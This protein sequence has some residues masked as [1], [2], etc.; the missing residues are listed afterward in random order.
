MRPSNLPAEQG[1]FV[2][3]GDELSE[4]ERL[5]AHSRLVTVTGAGGVG[6]TRLALR[7]AAER[8]KR[9]C[10]GVRV[11]YLST[12]SDPGLLDHALV[13]ALGVNDR[14]GRPPR[15]VLLDHLADRQLLLVLDG[16]EHLAGECARLVRE[17]LRRAPGLHVLTTGR[18]PLRTTGEAVL[19]LTPL[20]EDD[21]VRL[22]AD[23]AASA[24]PGFRVD[25][26]NRGEVRELCRRLDGIPLALE[27]AAGR[28][29][30]LSVGGMLHRLEGRRPGLPSDGAGR[31][32]AGHPTLRAAVGWSHE[33]CTPEERLLWARLSV[34]AGHVDPEAVEYVCTGPE[35]PPE[36]IPQVLDGLMTQSVVCREETAAGVRY[37]MPE[38]VR[39]YGAERLEALGDT[40]RLRRRHRD[41]H[42]G[43]AT[44]WELDW[45]GPRQAEVAACADTALPDLRAALELCMETPQETY[46]AQ[47]LAGTL[48]FYW[49]GCGRL[50]EGRHWLDRAVAL[51][52]A[53]S[54]NPRHDATRL[55]ALWVLGHVAILQGDGA[56]AVRALEECDAAARAAG[57][58]AA[59]AC[60]AH[61]RGSLA[62]LQN[63]LPGAERLLRR[64]LAEYRELGELNCHVLMA[65][66]TLAMSLLLQGDPEE[67]AAL[68]EEVRSVCAEHGDHWTRAYALYVLAYTCWIRGD[69][70]AARELL[71]GC[72]AVSHGFGDLVGLVPAI[73]LLAL[74]TACSGDAV[75]AA[76]LLGAAAP[77]REAVGLRL[78]DSGCFRAPVA[79]CE[80]R[81]SGVL[82]TTE[83][84]ARLAE[85]RELTLDAAVEM[86]L[87]MC[88]VPARA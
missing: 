60:A 7:A 41:W 21:A 37:R 56:Q 25:D 12:L 19:P 15:T 35:L 24:A 34:F 17:M 85:G 70:G 81:A 30:V 69:H 29:P 39:A 1:R 88:A 43:L 84:A 57:D 27:L 58:L 66:V 4:L 38:P 83:Y 54:G 16:F 68:C 45:F 9:Y 47:Y 6:K 61:R 36:R 76:V 67:A 62:L 48:W 31:A 51:G 10:D 3:R 13:T 22:F 63:D 82:G 46:L 28:L 55:K 86:A 87:A 26:G 75:M 2:G 5:L 71:A 44:W 33:L 23:R 18:H 11:A 14:T 32:P 8:E 42:M 78:F 49:V 64:A 79:R 52:P 65:Q 53:D 80:E 59:A 50:A 74:V 20:T 40:G 72:I 77:V 73:E